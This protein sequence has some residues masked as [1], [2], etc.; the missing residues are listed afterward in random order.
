[1]MNDLA[2]RLLERFPG[3]GGLP[4]ELLSGRPRVQ[5]LVDRVRAL[6]TSGEA[7]A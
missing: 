5:D 6:T 2:A 7:A 3:V 4:P 1:M